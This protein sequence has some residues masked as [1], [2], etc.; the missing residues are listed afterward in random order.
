[1]TM[2]ER[3]ALTQQAKAAQSNAAPSQMAPVP[4]SSS[5]WDGLDVLARPTSTSPHPLTAKAVSSM[6]SPPNNGSIEND[7]WGLSE[8]SPPTPSVSQ[9]ALAPTKPVSESK[10]TTLWDLDEFGPS[11]PQ[12]SQPL[13]KVPSRSLSGTPGDFDFGDRED[14]L[15]TGGD[16]DVEDTFGI[17]SSYAERPE[18]DILGDLGKPVV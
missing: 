5:L 13:S 8:F 10:T 2:A 17:R 12:T 6:T 15:L 3:A 11:E 14:G 16:S 4:T 18:D 1:M 7:D 9:S